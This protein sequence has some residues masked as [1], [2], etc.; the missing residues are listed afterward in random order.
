MRVAENCP[1]SSSMMRTCR[2]GSGATS[3]R[4]LRLIARMHGSGWYAKPP[5]NS[6][7]RF[8]QVGSMARR[9]DVAPG[10]ASHLLGGNGLLSCS[11]HFG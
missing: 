7:A 11:T 3:T 2:I 9:V 6:I 4:A 10:A 1:V 5:F 8:G